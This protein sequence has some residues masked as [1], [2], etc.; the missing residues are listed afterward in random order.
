MDYQLTQTGAQVQEILDDAPIIQQ[1]LEAVEALLPEDVSTG[2]KLVDYNQMDTLLQAKQDKLTE[3]T[4][5]TK[6]GDLSVKYGVNIGYGITVGSDNQ[7]KVAITPGSITKGQG[8]NIFTAIDTIE[9]VIPSAASAQNKLT[10]KNYVDSAIAT[11]SANFVGTFE[12]LAELQAVQNP[13]NNDYGFVIE[14]DAQ[15]NEYYDRYKFNGTQWLFEYKVE[16]TPFT[17]DQW[18]AIQSGIT[19]ALVTKLNALPTA[20]QLNTQLAGKQDTIDDLATIRSGAAAGATA[21]QPAALQSG[22]AT[23]QD[24]ITD[25]A[26]IRS[27]AAAGATAAANTGDKAYDAA[28]FSGLGRKN[29]PKN[30][31]E[32]SGTDKNVLTQAMINTANTIY[33]IQY[34]YDLN[35]QTITLP[36]GCVLQ[37]DGGSISN[38]EITFNNGG[39]HSFGTCFNDVRLINL[40]RIEARWFGIN[41]SNTDNSTELNALFAWLN[42]D[43]AQGLSQMFG[44]DASV[45]FEEED[46][47]ISSTLNIGSVNIV[48]NPAFRLTNDNTTAVIVNGAKN[49]KM[50]FRVKN[51]AG[52]ADWSNADS[53]GVIIKNCLYCKFLI[54]N[55]SHFTYGIIVRADNAGCAWNDF[56]IINIYA[57]LQ[58]FVVESLNNGWPNANNVYGGLSMARN[59]GQYITGGT[60]PVRGIVFKNDG[61]YGANGWSF[62][63]PWIEDHDQIS[64]DGKPYIPIDLCDY[65]SGGNYTNIQFVT[66]RTEITSA[67]LIKIRKENVDVLSYLDFDRNRDWFKDENGQSCLLVRTGIETPYTKLCSYNFADHLNAK[68][69]ISKGK[70]FVG[71]GT[72]GNVAEAFGQFGYAFKSIIIENFVGGV[73]KFSPTKR[74]N[75]GF[76]DANLN[77]VDVSTIKWYGSANLY[78]TNLSSPYKNYITTRVDNANGLY[79]YVTNAG[80]AK[81]MVIGINDGQID[82]L[83]DSNLKPSFYFPYGKVDD[84]IYAGAN[85]F[86]SIRAQWNV[87][88]KYINETTGRIYYVNVAGSTGTT[89]ATAN[90][91]A[92]SDAIVVSSASD[93]KVGDYINHD[94]DVYRITEI[95][96]TNV[97]LDKNLTS[98]ISNERI[99]FCNPLYSL[100]GYLNVGIT[101]ER[102]LLSAND[103]GAEYYDTEL[104]K[105]L[106]WNGSR[107]VDALGRS[108]TDLILTS[109]FFSR[110]TADGASLVTEDA[111]IDKLLGNTLVW[112]QLLNKNLQTSTIKGIS[113]TRNGDGS[114]TFV[115]TNDGTGSSVFYIAQGINFIAGH[116]YY[117]K[118]DF[119]NV[120]NNYAVYFSTGFSQYDKEVLFEPTTDRSNVS[121]LFTIWSGKTLSQVTISPILVDLTLL[122][123]AGN[124]PTIEQFRVDFP[125][126]DYP[127]VL[128][129]IMNVNITAFE[130]KA[131]KDRWTDT[132]QIPVATLTAGGNVVFPNGMC[133]VGDVH[134]ELTETT[135]IVRIGMRAYTAGDENDTSVVT[136]KTNTLYVLSTPQTLTLDNPLVFDYD[137]SE[138]GTETFLP[139]NST[140]TP[141]TAMP[142]STIT[143]KV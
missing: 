136:D 33:V 133:S 101:A 122:Y 45:I 132:L 139:Q 80:S 128:Q 119:V 89:N 77:N 137:A 87:G 110:I 56:T 43:Y 47:N 48:G 57:A 109:Q 113:C 106:F 94:D 59:S 61:S 54:E 9:A 4:T 34:D 143:Y 26:A 49:K 39:V 1:E 117:L 22:L 60:E 44:V 108:T 68:S 40:P 37:F 142:I 20:Q 50:E 30:I 14:T 8:A 17:A 107:W 120:Y 84:D 31:V 78:V 6:V 91:A 93:L 74:V 12:S 72:Y 71:W 135:A 41:P 127:R 140:G 100:G 52:V 90:G 105:K 35:G 81:Y 85:S 55:I 23:K 86:L 25:L 88:D 73:F 10:D 28:A 51:A 53:I 98:A 13:T 95:S 70:K 124:E 29:L 36:A 129:Q 11:S 16:S 19:S 131:R 18:A 76:L 115:G 112:N 27:G 123:G 32:V 38:G 121:L 99:T 126:E 125:N 24:T 42:S 141:A 75:I 7:T 116:K 102:P 138:G 79:F 103:A 2:N 111:T 46:Y 69:Y 58:S 64:I 130:S 66:P 5:G 65:I 83:H 118:T 134:D 63:S 104:E 96:G 97:T 82:I 62:Y 21:V 92:G 67:T 15:G 3:Q 114:F